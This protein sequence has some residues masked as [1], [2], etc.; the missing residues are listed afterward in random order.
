MLSSFC[1]FMASHQGTELCWDG[2]G[3]SAPPA[4]QGTQ[5]CCPACAA[6]HLCKYRNAFIGLPRN[7]GAP[8]NYEISP[9]PFRKGHNVRILGLW[10]ERFNWFTKI[11]TDKVVPPSAPQSQWIALR[12]TTLTL[13]NSDL[14]FSFF[15]KRSWHKTQETLKEHFYF[16]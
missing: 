14:L 9:K 11:T 10:T 16:N 8:Q 15:L 5:S 6:P 4:T 12:V 3:I 7:F 1:S 13:W 2:T